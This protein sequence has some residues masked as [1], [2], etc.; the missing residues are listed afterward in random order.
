MIFLP[1]YVRSMCHQSTV[2]NKVKT[3]LIRRLRGQIKQ[4]SSLCDVFYV[5]KII[6]ALVLPNDTLFV[7]CHSINELATCKKR[8]QKNYRSDLIYIEDNGDVAHSI[9]SVICFLIKAKWPKI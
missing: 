4:Y 9:N 5:F 2:S 1:F 8:S 6:Y 7:F 3:Y